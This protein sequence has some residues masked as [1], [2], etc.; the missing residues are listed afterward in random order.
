[1]NIGKFAR[2]LPSLDVVAV[3]QAPSPESN[4]NSPLPVKGLLSQYLTT[5][6]I[7]ERPDR[8]ILRF[9]QH[10]DSQFVM[11]HHISVDLKLTNAEVRNANPFW[12]MI[13]PWI[14][15]VIQLYFVLGEIMVR[16]LS[17]T[18]I[19][20]T[21]C[22]VLDMH[23]LVFDLRIWSLA[24]STSLLERLLA[25]FK[26]CQRGILLRE[27]HSNGFRSFNQEGT[28]SLSSFVTFQRARMQTETTVARFYMAL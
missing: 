13:S 7:G 14:T 9:L 12:R 17:H 25:A 5:D 2:L 27:L 10:E 21:T 19:H 26:G 24:G 1:M 16:L 28:R 23:G 22:L 18:Q 4:P 3:S 8:V 6:L 15:T 11:I 20:C